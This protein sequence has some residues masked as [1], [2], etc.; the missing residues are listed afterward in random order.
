[1]HNLRNHLN[2]LKYLKTALYNKVGQLIPLKL[3]GNIIFWYSIFQFRVYNQIDTASLL[4]LI[5]L[6]HVDEYPPSSMERILKIS[7]IEFI[8]RIYLN[9]SGTMADCWKIPFYLAGFLA[10]DIVAKNNA[11]CK[12]AKC[13]PLAIMRHL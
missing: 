11:Q 8:F 7:K 4:Q 1:M 6:S 12:N 13:E 10:P 5:E 3:R 2:F 9:C